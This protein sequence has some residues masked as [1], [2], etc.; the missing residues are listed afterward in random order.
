MQDLV[1]ISFTIF[2]TI[3]LIYFVYKFMLGLDMPSKDDELQITE[4]DWLEQLNLLYRD[5]NYYI[6]EKLAKKYLEKKFANDEVRLI[7]ARSLFESGKFYDAI[8]QARIISRHKPE[9]FEIKN[10]I[11]NCYLNASKPLEAINL[12]KE[13]VEQDEANSVAIKELAQVYLDTNQKISARK[14]YKRLEPLV[15]SNQEKL[16]IKSL[17]AGIHIEFKEFDDAINEYQEILEIYPAN[18]QIKK[19]LVTLYKLQ[20]D[21]EREVEL[22][23]EIFEAHS[24]EED[25]I[26]A[27]NFLSD[28]YAENKNYEKALEYAKMVQ[29]NPLA[30]KIAINTKISN[31]LIKLDQVDDSIEILKNLI[32][33]N[34]E[35]SDLKKSLSDA[36]QSKDDFESAI[37]T[38][39]LIL[40]GTSV[41]KIKKVHSEISN[42]YS[43]W[44]M[45]LFD[46]DENEECFKKFNSALE[47]D[48]SNPEL[49][50]R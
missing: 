45:F 40:D 21:F 32:L 46:K 33:E 16:K 38:Y 50:Y 12:L 11:V 49:Y 29:Q 27:L 30:D 28:V 19:N 3:G 10:F 14:M 41:E 6:I 15:F 43:N 48:A 22:A 37:K 8:E 9:D 31:I 18:I 25:D 39:E 20:D 23:N 35:N 1:F 4:S 44:A 36:Y 26:W 13:I 24:S 7:L 17:I 5:R 34:P 2:V 42:I 47:Y